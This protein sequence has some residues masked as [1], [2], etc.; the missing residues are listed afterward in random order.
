MDIL[1]TVHI[2]GCA[3]NGMTRLGVLSDE[4]KAQLHLDTS[5]PDTVFNNVLGRILKFGPKESHAGGADD[6]LP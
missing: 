1:G 5:P 2:I 3:E 6:S 4:E